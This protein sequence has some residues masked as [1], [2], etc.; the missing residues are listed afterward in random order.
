MM[1]KSSCQMNENTCDN[2]RQGW[3]D[4]EEIRERKNSSLSASLE[5][6]R[7]QGEKFISPVVNGSYKLVMSSFYEMSRRHIYNLGLPIS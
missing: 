6:T 5:Q 4:K 1:R 3:S 7:T 2:T